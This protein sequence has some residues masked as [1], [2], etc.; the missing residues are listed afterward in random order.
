MK[1][2]AYVATS[3]PIKDICRVAMSDNPEQTCKRASENLFTPGEWVVRAKYQLPEGCEDYGSPILKAVYGELDE[4][5]YSDMFYKC[6]PDIAAAAIELCLAREYRDMNPP[7]VPN[8]IVYLIH[9]LTPQTDPRTPNAIRL[10]TRQGLV[11][12]PPEH[13]VYL[14]AIPTSN[15]KET[16][17]RFRTEMYECGYPLHHN[18]HYAPLDDAIACLEN[19]VVV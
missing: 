11:F 15:A 5:V 1:L 14:A 18:K 4:Y 12:I 17:S 7:L 8:D 3:T 16:L 6:H 2:Y 13:R 10:V 19:A 9:D